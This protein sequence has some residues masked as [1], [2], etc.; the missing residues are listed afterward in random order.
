M[1]FARRVR[2]AIDMAACCGESAWTVTQDPDKDGWETDGGLPG[3]GL[4][5][6]KAKFLAAAANAYEK[7]E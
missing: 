1:W 2:N 5:E 6:R 3:Y 4:T 7:K